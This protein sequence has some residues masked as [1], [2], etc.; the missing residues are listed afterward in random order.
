VRSSVDVRNY[1]QN[2]DIPHEI[3]LVNNP[4]KTAERAAALLR[5][6][7]SEVAKSILFMAESKPV[8]IVVPGNKKVNYKK[9]KHVLGTDH[10]HLA[11]AQSLRDLTGYLIGA[12]PPLAHQTK[13]KILIDESIM[14]LNV[15]YTAG[16]ELNAMLKI[17][18]QDLKKVSEAQI[19]DIAQDLE[20]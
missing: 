5:L 12:T 16:G 1:L 14:Y 7:P 8:L 3:F 17:R 15:I 18:P 11:P 20:T 2:K 13:M 4:T 6:K 10:V 19:V 9:L